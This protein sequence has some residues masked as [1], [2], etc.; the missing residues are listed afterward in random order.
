MPGSHDR[1]SFLRELLRGASRAAAEIDSLRTRAE[2]FEPTWEDDP[3]AGVPDT[4]F[5][6]LPALPAARLAT[7]EELRQLCGELGRPEWADEAASLA[8]RSIRLT[9]G[10]AGRSWLGGSPGTPTPLAW[11]TWK[12]RE[13]AFL[14]QLDLA[15]LPESDLPRGGALLVFF[16][17]D[18]APAGYSPDEAGSCRVIHVDAGPHERMVR[19][20][21][22]PEIRLTATE[23]L[24]LPLD[25]VSFEPEFSELETWNEL[26]ER[27]AGL[28]GI[29]LEDITGDYHALHRM[30]G[31]PDSLADSMASEADLLARGVDVGLEPYTDLTAEPEGWRLLLQLSSDD[32]AGISLGAFERLF[33]WIRDDDLRAG[34][35][36]DVWAFVR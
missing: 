15:E 20:G 24:T 25:P 19:D 12:G 22:L 36:D 11:P 1:R 9:H 4:P 34:R 26:R 17:L 18:Q 27:L 5:S 10:D 2:A 32:D 13:L 14:A 7:V 3:L 29:E 16:A 33:V 6:T 35:F 8:L 28:Q 30:L 23:E 21:A 31:Y